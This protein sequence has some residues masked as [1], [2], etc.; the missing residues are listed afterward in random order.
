MRRAVF[1]LTA[2]LVIVFLIAP[3]AQMVAVKGNFLTGPSIGIASPESYKVGRVY[4]ET[5]VDLAISIYQFGNSSEITAVSYSLDGSLNRTLNILNDTKKY[6]LATGTM[7][8]LTNGYHFIGAYTLDAQG[9]SMS[10]STTFLVNTSFSYP[11][12]LLSPQNITYTKNEV[13]LTYI[14]N[15]EAKYVGYVL[16]N[17][18]GNSLTGNTTLSDLSEG[19]HEVTIKAMNGFSI[20]SE[21]KVYF[22]INTAKPEKPL[23]LGNQTIALGIAVAVIVVVAVAVVMLY[24]KRTR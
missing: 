19:Q 20:Y 1:A 10:T 23:A 9:K 6:Y 7:E 24:K 12:L 11:T 14:I 18:S 2:I 22:E 16:D 3:I 8:N 15:K 17:S 5:N 4:Q 21:N 13:P